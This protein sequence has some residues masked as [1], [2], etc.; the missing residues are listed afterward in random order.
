MKNTKVKKAG[1]SFSIE[2]LIA[3]DEQ[4]KKASSGSSSCYLEDFLEQMQLKDAESKRS[5]SDDF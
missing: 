3:E 4:G 5:K 2:A 1:K